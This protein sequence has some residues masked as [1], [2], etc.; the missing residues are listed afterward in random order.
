MVSE[1]ESL[2]IAPEKVAQAIL[3]VLKEQ[4]AIDEE[5]LI[6]E[7]AR[8]FDYA[9]VRDNVHASMKRG[10]EYIFKNNMMQFDGSRYKLNTLL[11]KVT[12]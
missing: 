7:N 4:F 6:S 5:G 9:S 10:I 2:D 8:L 12:Y 3:H 1:L 11:K